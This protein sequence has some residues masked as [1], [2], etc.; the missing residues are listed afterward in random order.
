MRRYKHSDKGKDL[1]DTSNYSALADEY[2]ALKGL[3]D[4]LSPSLDNIKQKLMPVK[5]ELKLTTDA[6]NI[7][8]KLAKNLAEN[9]GQQLGNAVINSSTNSFSKSNI[10]GFLEKILSN[11]WNEGRA[12]GG[13]IAVGKSYLVGEK[14]PE[15]FTPHT[16]GIVT[17]NNYMSSKRQSINVVLNVNSTANN[18]FGK[19]HNQQLRELTRAIYNLSLR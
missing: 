5:S 1:F 10:F 11:F 8:N 19:N 16:S 12:I 13:N 2:K 17:A 6:M 3:I 15:L 9:I 14:G 7:L 4:H 18:G